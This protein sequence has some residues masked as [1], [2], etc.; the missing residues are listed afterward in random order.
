MQCQ[1][2]Y[3]LIDKDLASISETLNNILLI[4]YFVNR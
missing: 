2:G 3:Y 4:T 1:T